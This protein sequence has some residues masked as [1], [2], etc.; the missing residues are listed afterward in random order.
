M[1]QNNITTPTGFMPQLA[2]NSFGQI[3]MITNPN[4][5]QPGVSYFVPRGYMDSNSS[6]SYTLP[7]T[8][9]APFI[10]ALPQPQVIQQNPTNSAPALLPPQHAEQH[11]VQQQTKQKQP[12]LSKRSVEVSVVE[13]TFQLKDQTNARIKNIKEKCISH[14]IDGQLIIETSKPLNELRFKSIKKK[15]KKRQ[16][17]SSSSSLDHNDNQF[18]KMRLLPNSSTIS[19]I[20]PSQQAS[21][22][23]S[24]ECQLTT[25]LPT[26]TEVS[27]SIDKLEEKP[28][29]VKDD[30]QKLR[31]RMATW[32]VSDVV[33]FIEEHDDIKQYA[34][35]FA[36]D[37]VDGKALLLMIDRNL[38]LQMLASMFKHGPAMK[39]EAVLSKYKQNE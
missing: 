14:Y 5:H 9:Y 31:A 25:T 7:P 21:L 22:E 24:A 20:Q 12:T 3:Y 2:A 33:K 29:F 37:E 13:S 32:S 30:V 18:K 34:P 16:S 23:T 10:R 28:V 17:S 19:T 26:V 6:N 11:Q 35:R 1:A 36:D 39:I 4:Q 27:K 38:N 8:M 15:E